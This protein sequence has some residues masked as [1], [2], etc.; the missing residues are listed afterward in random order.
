MTNEEAL[1]FLAELEDCADDIGLWSDRKERQNNTFRGFEVNAE[2]VEK[3]E[4][5]KK[6]CERLAELDNAVHFEGV[7]MN[8]RAQDGMAKITLPALFFSSDRRVMNTLAKLFAEA[9]QVFFSC[10]YAV[11][12][13][14][15]AGDDD[16]PGEKI[17][18]MTFVV[19]N[20]WKIYMKAPF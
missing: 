14:E 3:L 20:M 7:Y 16:E 4:R 6:L 13:E 10:P 15:L 8:S 5:L 17:L 19:D 18:V 12:D 9:D 2:K 1:N 11:Y